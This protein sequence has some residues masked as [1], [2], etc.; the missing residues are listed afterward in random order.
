MA[1]LTCDAAYERP[2][3]STLLC[4]YVAG[5]SSPGHS[6]RTIKLEDAEELLRDTVFSKQADTLVASMLEAIA[7]GD[8]DLYLEAILA[9][10]HNRKRSKRGVWSPTPHDA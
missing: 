8:L 6:W 4:Q 1:V 9:G 3:S 5:H 2:D 7:R 10:C